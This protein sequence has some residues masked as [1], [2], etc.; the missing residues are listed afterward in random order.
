MVEVKKT[1]C[2]ICVRKLQRVGKVG[3]TAETT[4]RLFKNEP[5]F[6]Q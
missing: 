3:T 5:H 4:T 2:Y 1:K 6:S